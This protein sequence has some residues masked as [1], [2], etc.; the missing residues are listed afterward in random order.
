MAV[1]KS[2]RVPSNWKIEDAKF[3]TLVVRDLSDRLDD[4][5]NSI[6][7]RLRAAGGENT[8]IARV[9]GTAAIAGRS[10]AIRIVNDLSRGHRV[11]I[12]LFVY[13]GVGDSLAIR[14]EG[15]AWS[16]IVWLR[17]LLVTA[18]FLSSMVLLLWAYFTFFG[19]RGALAT[20]FAKKYAQP[21]QPWEMYKS[22][23]IDG[24]SGNP[25]WTLLEF[26]RQ[27]PKMFLERMAGPPAILGGIVGFIIYRL[28]KDWVKFPCNL[29]GW[30]TP[31]LFRSHVRQ[32]KSWAEETVFG[33]LAETF[34]RFDS[35][36]QREVQK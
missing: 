33:V 25:A 8:Q 24:G 14:F 1:R 31:D 29:M 36:V 13:C 9:P 15:T 19:S 26:L 35:D 30:P 3:D 22:W 20:D 34:Q 11:A 4:V 16:R 2:V 12:D 7:E 28:P 23:V 32:V 6:V 5:V 10:D 21:G 27:D 18:F 17:S